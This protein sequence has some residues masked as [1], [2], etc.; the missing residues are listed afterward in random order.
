MAWMGFSSQSNNS[1]LN[2][3][4]DTT[5]NLGII[6]LCLRGVTIHT[7]K[8]DRHL[9]YTNDCNKINNYIINRR[10]YCLKSL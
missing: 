6:L 5:N 8:A 7:D 3:S 10:G 4:L 9:H 1:F 2:I